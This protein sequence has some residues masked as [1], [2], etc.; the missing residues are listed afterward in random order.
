MTILEEIEEKKGI[1]KL[2]MIMQALRSKKGCAWDKKQTHQTLKKYLLEEAFE[3]LEALDENDDDA[4]SS[5]LGD[6][7]LQIVFHCQIAHEEKRFDFEDVCEKCSEM[8]IRR[9]PHVFNENCDLSPKEVEEQWEQ[10]KKTEKRQQKRDSILDSIP[11]SM[12]AIYRQEKMHEKAA[13][14]GFDWVN[15]QDVCDKLNEEVCEFQEEIAKG[16][17]KKAKEELGDVLM[18]CLN[19]CRHLDSS[20]EEVTK[21]ANKKYYQRFTFI[22]KKAKEEGLSLKDLDLEKWDSWWQ[23]SKVL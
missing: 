11:S 4:F 21:Q 12:P 2:K 3:V 17:S 13:S 1:E 19:L 9:H 15:L 23:E 18:V 14:Q 6:L 22:E 5:E 20:L 16:D 8:L 7:L 10:I